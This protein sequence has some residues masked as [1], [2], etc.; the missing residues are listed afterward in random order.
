M[1]DTI[2]R[3]RLIDDMQKERDWIEENVKDRQTSFHMMMETGRVLR[4]IREQ[5]CTEEEEQ[6]GPLDE[7]DG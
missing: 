1:G 7:S 4:I 5:K 2:S 3:Q 6:N